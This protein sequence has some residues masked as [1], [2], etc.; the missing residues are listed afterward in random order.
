MGEFIHA[1]IEVFMEGDCSP[2][3]PW[4]CYTLSFYVDGR[5]RNTHAPS[6]ATTATSLLL[7]DCSEAEITCKKSASSLELTES[8]FFLPWARDNIGHTVLLDKGR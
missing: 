6:L 7:G 3:M 1:E 4:L 8:C 2:P 5:G